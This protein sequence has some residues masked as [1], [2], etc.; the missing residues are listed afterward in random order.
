[1]SVADVRMP[2]THTDDGLRA[3]ISARRQLPGAPTLVLSQYVEVSYATD[4][5]ADG[6]PPQSWRPGLS[7]RGIG[8]SR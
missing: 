5:L 3:A 4:L 2:P 7:P 1:M 6:R 8:K